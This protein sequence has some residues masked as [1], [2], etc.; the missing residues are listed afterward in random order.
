MCSR[1]N[2][3][4]QAETRVLIC[5]SAT[6]S[7]SLVYPS[8]SAGS[9]RFRSPTKFASHS[10]Q[11]VD[12]HFTLRTS[13]SSILGE[14]FGYPIQLKSIYL[15]AIYSRAAYFRYWA[16]LPPLAMSC[17]RRLHLEAHQ[18]L[19]PRQRKGPRLL[20]ARASKKE[21]RRKKS[22]RRVT[23]A[24]D[25]SR[26]HNSGAT[27]IILT[28][29]FSEKP[30]RAHVGVSALPRP[31]QRGPSPVSTA[32]CCRTAALQGH[33]EKRVRASLIM[34]P[35]L[36]VDGCTI[37]PGLLRTLVPRG[38]VPDWRNDESVAFKSE[39]SRSIISL[40]PGR[41][42]KILYHNADTPSP[43]PPLQAREDGDSGLLLGL[44][45]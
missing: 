18:W 2:S 26:S 42:L 11:H 15:T 37:V 22:L 34:W 32:S 25:Q 13:S 33:I 35:P 40:E 45:W 20:I 8:R 39:L 30:H 36:P 19:C 17:S 24:S 5:V 21:R 16:W 3:V 4:S 14:C 44:C 27:D 10:H 23:L 1:L 31:H 6:R 12:F 29:R 28:C 9:S 41:L 43:S 38:G 7:T